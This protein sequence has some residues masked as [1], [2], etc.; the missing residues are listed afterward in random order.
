MAKININ[1]DISELEEEF[2]LDIEHTNEI[3]S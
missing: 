3:L 2:I 1:N